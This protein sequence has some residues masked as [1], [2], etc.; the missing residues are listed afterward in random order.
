MRK[1]ETAR[2]GEREKG[3]G[4]KR[5][6]FTKLNSRAIS[7]TIT[8]R[9]RRYESQSVA[10]SPTRN[11]ETVRT[12][13]RQLRFN[14]LFAS[15]CSW[16]FPLPAIGISPIV[17][18]RSRVETEAG[19]RAGSPPRHL[20]LIT[21]ERTIISPRAVASRAAGFSLSFSPDRSDRSPSRWGRNVKR[22]RRCAGCVNNRYC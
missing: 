19:R 8:S 20:E 11:L 3:R 9:S 12:S 13:E 15:C 21:P 5:E 22:Q 4:K 6:R 14:D 17:S 16:R 10:L 7:R 18:S 1:R 2:K